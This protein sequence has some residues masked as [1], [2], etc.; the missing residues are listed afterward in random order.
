MEEEDWI[1]PNGLC[2]HSKNF[3]SLCMRRETIVEFS[4]EDGLDCIYI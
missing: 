1:P 4:A 3:A 2:S